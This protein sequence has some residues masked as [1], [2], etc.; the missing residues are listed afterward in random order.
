MELE[1]SRALVEDGHARDVR[2]KQVR[3]ELDPTPLAPDRGRDRAGQGRLAD[4]W[5]VLEQKVSLGE[6]A[7]ERKLDD[8]GLTQDHRAHIAGEA[9]CDI[10]KSLDLVGS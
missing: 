4:P 6:Q 10:G 7:R 1:L 8:L 9:C 3:G 2:R 5:Y